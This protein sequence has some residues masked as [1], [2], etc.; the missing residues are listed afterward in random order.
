MASLEEMGDRLGKDRRCFALYH[1]VMSDEP[2]LFIEVALTRGIASSIHDIIEK[3]ADSR[4]QKK[5]PDTA[6]FYSINNT[7]N[8]LAGLGLGKILIFQVV[9][10]L[11]TS[12][13]AIKTF[14]TLSPIPGFWERY[15]KPI[16]SGGEHSF[17]LKQEKVEEF[18]PKKIQQALFDLHQRHG[19][20]TPLTLAG[21]LC[22]VLSGPEWLEHPGYRKLLEDPLTKLAYFYLSREKD[23]RGKPLNPVANFHIGNGANL[24]LRNVHFAANRSPRGLMES[25]GMMVNYLYSQSW[26][27]QISRS[28]QFLLPWRNSAEGKI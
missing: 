11:K 18:F 27:Q 7:Q 6:T 16:L 4:E 21:L 22:K 23:R 25:C 14:A 20:Q 24:G 28:M 10:A 12:D 13:P 8:G 15:L 1:R 3:K 9:E 2:V 26:L 19:V 17:L 5:P